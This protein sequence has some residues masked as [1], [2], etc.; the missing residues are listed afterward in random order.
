M[1]FI[2]S[3][4]SE[5]IVF[6]GMPHPS[7]SKIFFKFG[8]QPGYLE[9]SKA[10]ECGSKI[11]FFISKQWLVKKFKVLLIFYTLVVLIQ[12]TKVISVRT[13]LKVYNLPIW[14]NQT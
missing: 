5:D 14:G 10:C 1:S 9:K 11:S 2:I 8:T 3:F 13:P 4:N 6:V 7:S 12:D